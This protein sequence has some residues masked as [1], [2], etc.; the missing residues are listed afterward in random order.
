MEYIRYSAEI[1]MKN[2]ILEKHTT[3][4]LQIILFGYT[5]IVMSQP[6]KQ[7]ISSLT[8][9]FNIKGGLLYGNQCAVT[10]INNTWHCSNK[11][12]LC[13]KGN[14][15]YDSEKVSLQSHF[16]ILK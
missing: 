7:N 15:I 9:I 4:N 13:L 2:I 14:N 6:N 3:D 12:Y 11:N 10:F 5:N 16:Q 1:L 8:N